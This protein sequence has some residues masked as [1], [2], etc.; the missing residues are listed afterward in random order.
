MI[1]YKDFL[2]DI[3]NL[4]NLLDENNL[5]SSNEI[6]IVM[7]KLTDLEV[8]HNKLITSIPYRIYT[9]N[10]LKEV[11]INFSKELKEALINF[12]NSV[13]TENLFENLIIILDSVIKTD[14]ME[15]SCMKALK[16]PGQTM[17]IEIKQKNTILIIYFL[18]SL[19]CL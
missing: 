4:T 6:D 19:K 18:F 16:T 13:N 5:K 7:K 8:I 10:T 17:K 2:K 11:T 3:H 15:F 1:D 12:S 14:A 9:A